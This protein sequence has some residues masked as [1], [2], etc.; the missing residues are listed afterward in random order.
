MQGNDADRIS[1]GEHSHAELASG[2]IEETEHTAQRPGP[3]QEA[4]RCRLE[5]CIIH[6]CSVQPPLCNCQHQGTIGTKGYCPGYVLMAQ[7]L[8]GGLTRGGV[9]HASCLIIAACHHI[10]TRHH[11][12]PI[13]TKGHCPDCVLMAQGF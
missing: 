2:W 13:R 11:V 12:L 10:A 1:S 6:P 5:N 8:T 9:P 3:R 4:A 7:G